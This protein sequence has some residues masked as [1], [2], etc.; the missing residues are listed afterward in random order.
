LRKYDATQHGNLLH[1][2][3]KEFHC[4]KVVICP[5]HTEQHDISMASAESLRFINAGNLCM[6]NMGNNPMRK[7]LFFPW[8]HGFSP[9]A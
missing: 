6:N 4:E 8:K 2:E 5:V 7:K 1:Y 9:V 3:N